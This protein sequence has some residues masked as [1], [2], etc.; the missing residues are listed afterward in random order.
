MEL[1]AA[2]GEKHDKAALHIGAALSHVG[3]QTGANGRFLEGTVNHGE[4][5]LEQVYLEGL[6]S[7]ERIHAGEI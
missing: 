4:P 1:T 6:L 3:L 2:C 7:M 5:M